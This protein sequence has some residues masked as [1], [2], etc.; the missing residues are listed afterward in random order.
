MFFFLLLL[1]M[2]DVISF[3]KV[4]GYWFCWVAINVVAYILVGA[5]YYSFLISPIIELFK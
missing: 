3:W 5:V 2:F 1:W 4:I